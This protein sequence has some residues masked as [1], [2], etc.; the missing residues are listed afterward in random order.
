MPAQCTPHKVLY[1]MR[2]RLFNFA[3][4]LS[5]ALCLFVLFQVFDA[6]IHP[7]RYGRLLLELPLPFN[8]QLYF[9]DSFVMRTRGLLHKEEWVNGRSKE[10]AQFNS[11]RFKFRFE[12]DYWNHSTT[13]SYP[14][15]EDRGP[16]AGWTIGVPFW[17]VILVSAPAP[18]IWLARWARQRERRRRRQRGVCEK[19]GYDLRASPARCPECGTSATAATP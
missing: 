2:R 17:F 12:V 16:I 10:V 7:D 19:C 11:E 8:L 13:T 15:P 18:S 1:V 3:A 6:S 14:P 4:G 5:G 9:R